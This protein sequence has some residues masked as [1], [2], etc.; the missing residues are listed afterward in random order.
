MIKINVKNIIK[1]TIFM[2]TDD[3]QKVYGEICKLLKQGNTIEIS[4]D[5]LDMLISH[6]L[7]EAIGKLYKEFD[8]DDLEKALS[9]ANIDQ[10]DLELLKDK[11]IPTAKMHFKNEMKAEKIELDILND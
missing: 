6:A 3:G 1:K 11:V 2:S 9:Y 5:G 8:W 7:N 10:D 4:F